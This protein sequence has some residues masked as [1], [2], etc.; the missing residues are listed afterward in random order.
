MSIPSLLPGIFEEDEEDR[1]PAAGEP[2]GNHPHGKHCRMVAGVTCLLAGVGYS[3]GMKATAFRIICSWLL[4]FA[5]LLPV[6]ADTDGFSAEEEGLCRR[7]SIASQPWA[8]AR[9]EVS[10]TEARTRAAKEGKPI[11]LVVNTGNVLGFV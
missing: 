6:R 10:L 5:P 9:W 11:F 4:T 3:R 1:E 7:L 2:C 8:S